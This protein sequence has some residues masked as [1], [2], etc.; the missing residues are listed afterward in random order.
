M[1]FVP[2]RENLSSMNLVCKVVFLVHGGSADK[3]DKIG[4]QK[5][6]QGDELSVEDAG[7][8]EMIY[9]KDGKLNSEE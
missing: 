6:T 2:V 8:D 7:A 5:T 1:V 4:V 9:V 3:Q